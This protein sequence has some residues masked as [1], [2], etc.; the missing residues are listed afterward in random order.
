MARLLEVTGFLMI[1]S[2]AAGTSVVL[3]L[4]QL[5]KTASTRGRVPTVMAAVL[6]LSTVTLA[7]SESL[8]RLKVR[9]LVTWKSPAAS[10][11]LMRI[12]LTCPTYGVTSPIFFTPRAL[13]PLRAAVS[14]VVLKASSCHTV[15]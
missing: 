4:V 2:T 15:T 3:R 8:M 5:M 11:Y 14:G 12:S 6:M 7:T 1:F 10:M 9:R 13:N